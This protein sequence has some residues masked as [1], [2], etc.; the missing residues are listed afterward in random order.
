MYIVTSKTNSN[1]YVC[2][3]IFNYIRSFIATRDLITS[4]PPTGR[5]GGFVPRLW[6]FPCKIDFFGY[7]FFD[8]FLY[9]KFWRLA[10]R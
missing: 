1:N 6:C 7:L 9:P 4:V 10:N 2:A 5:F 3:A 8:D